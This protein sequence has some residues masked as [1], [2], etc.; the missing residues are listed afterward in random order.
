VTQAPNQLLQHRART[1]RT[2]QTPAERRM[3]AMLGGSRLNG[4]KFRRQ[5]VIDQYI[6][7]FLCPALALVVEVDGASHT[8]PDRDARREDY[9]AS[10]GYQVMRFAN[11]QVMEQGDLVALAI[12]AQ[13]AQMPA[14]WEN[15]PRSY[16]KG[17]SLQDSPTPGPSPAGEGS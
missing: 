13:A 12:L 6:V 2:N 3:W 16:G 1:M 17:G 7:D 4:L 15:G 11:W 9:L 8:D 14:R 5:A 10:K